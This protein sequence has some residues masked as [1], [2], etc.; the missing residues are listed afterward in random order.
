MISRRDR[1][2][3]ETVA[4]LQVGV[5]RTTISLRP[6]IGATHSQDPLDIGAVSDRNKRWMDLVVAGNAS[7]LLEKGDENEL[8]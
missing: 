8:D 2:V 5:G 7:P 3:W 4:H 1:A 6:P